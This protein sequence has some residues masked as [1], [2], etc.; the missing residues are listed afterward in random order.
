ME[1]TRVFRLLEGYRG[2][3][4]A[5]LDEIAL[6]LV[7]L[8][9]LAAEL[10]EV[11]EADINPLL[12]DA[13][14]TVALDARMR[15]RA[16]EAAT[17]DRLAIRPYP[18]ELERQA[19]LADGSE[20]A[21]RPIRPE[22]EPSLREAFKKLTPQDVRFRFFSVMG[23]LSHELAARLTQIDYDREMALVAHP[24]DAPED[25]WGVVRLASD[26]D[27]RAAEF[28]VIV[29]SDRQRRGLGRLLMQHL[30]AY[31][32]S[33]GIGALWGSVLRQNRAMRATAEALGFTFRER[34]GNGDLVTAWLSLD[35]DQ[36]ST[37][38]RSRA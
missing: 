24:P 9:Q 4:P 20:I 33:R 23:E 5:A 29:R 37:E 8:S 19:T 30:V 11:A 1:E 35:D 27:R 15:V 34:E 16:V 7:K 14:G 18:R 6:C 31:A 10:P 32:R 38:G 3:P 2:E 13:K 22:D 25:I 12:A 17:R 36:A 21:L 26:P 28:A